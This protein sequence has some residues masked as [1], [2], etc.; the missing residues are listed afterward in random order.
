MTPSRFLLQ[1]VGPAVLAATGFEVLRRIAPAARREPAHVADGKLVLRR[2]KFETR[3]AI[4][5]GSFLVTVALA[6]FVW[7]LPY[8]QIGTFFVVV[9]TLLVAL[10]LVE[11]RRWVA[12]DDSGLVLHSPWV[13]ERSMLWTQVQAV[14]FGNLFGLHFRFT[15]VMTKPIRVECS[16]A[17]ITQLEDLMK[18]HLSPVVVGSALG[19]YQKAVPP[20][21]NHWSGP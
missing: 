15:S 9:I 12:T 16:Y 4:G 10:G 14:S 1:V 11:L 2:T 17:G 5:C 7:S 19:E 3:I 13:G 8:W 18:R 6:G 20:P 21:S